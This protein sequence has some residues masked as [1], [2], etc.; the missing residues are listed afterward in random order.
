MLTCLE[1]DLRPV[2]DFVGA[3]GLGLG[4]ET[5]S[6]SS[7]SLERSVLQQVSVEGEPTSPLGLDLSVLKD[8]TFFR[9]Y[10]LLFPRSS[11]QT[12]I[13]LLMLLKQPSIGKCLLLRSFSNSIPFFNNEKVLKRLFSRH[14][15]NESISTT[16]LT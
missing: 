15:N 16:L 10:F 8:E 1:A 11:L 4:C 14:L 12:I 5:R 3:S 2:D 13:R 7:D 9:N 6:N